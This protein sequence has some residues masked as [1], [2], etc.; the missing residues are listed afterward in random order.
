MATAGFEPSRFRSEVDDHFLCAVCTKVVQAPEECVKC[1]RLLCGSCAKSSSECP[2]CKQDLET[3]TPALYAR[4]VY[5]NLELH[6]AHQQ[7]G[8]EAVVTL[9]NLP[10]HESECVYVMVSCASPIC[11][12]TFMKKDKQNDCGKALVCSILCRTVMEFKEVLET[13]DQDDVLRQFHK[14]LNEAKALVESQVRADLEPM[15]R[16]I[17]N[18][19]AEVKEFAQKREEL[20]EELEERK[21]KYHPGKWNGALST[22]TCCNSSDKFALGCRK[23]A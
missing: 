20:V 18:K 6:C 3:K 14:F 11:T 9:G 19:L 7:N 8:C 5:N 10:S 21:W 13:K 12:N 4:K 1:Q 22:W 23:L 17:D 2:Y 16:E 15:Q